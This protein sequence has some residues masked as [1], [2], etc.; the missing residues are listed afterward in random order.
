MWRVDR[1]NVELYTGGRLLVYSFLLTDLHH[2]EPGGKYS[3]C[4]NVMIYIVYTYN[5]DGHHTETMLK[6]MLVCVCVIKA[7]F[8]NNLIRLKFNPKYFR[9]TYTYF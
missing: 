7:Q 4:V 1:V 2:R 3:N 9:H 6:A 5:K 8:N